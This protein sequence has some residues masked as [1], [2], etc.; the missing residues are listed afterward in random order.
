MNRWT[1]G[2]GALCLLCLPLLAAGQSFDLNSALNVVKGVSQSV[3]VGNMSEQEEVAV[4]RDVA[5]GVLGRYRL[6]E[7]ERLQRYLNQVGVWVAMQ[8]S[9]PGLPWRFAAIESPDINA[10]AVP[11][12]TVLVTQGMLK[13]LVN[14]AELGCVL[15]HEVAHVEHKDH[16]AVLQKTLLV[17]TGGNLLAAKQD[18]VLHKQLIGEGATLFNRSLD[19]DAERKADEEGVVL[20]ARAGYDPGTC[21]GFMQRLA[22]L[23]A[24]ANALEALYK[25]H[26]AASERKGDIEKALRRLQGASAG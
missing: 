12:G 14:E 16:L 22:G 11:G 19:R 1:R 7:D 3:S 25:T 20:A 21:L 9:R 4:G 17:Q 26:P 13:M 23:K 8:S 6:V 5:T 18:S 2:V 10:F 24:G 15:G